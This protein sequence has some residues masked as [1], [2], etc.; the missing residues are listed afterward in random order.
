[1]VVS[2]SVQGSPAPRRGIVTTLV[3]IASVFAFLGIFASWVDQQVFDTDE[4]TDTSTELLE[5]EEVRRAVSTYLV[6][7]L[8]KN[9]DVADEL[10][11]VLP[12]ETQALA[13]PVAGALRELAPRAANRALESP[14]VQDVWAAANRRAHERFLD[15]IEDRGDAVSTAGGDVT[16]D[17]RLLVENLS[18][19]T[20]FGQKLAAK[21]PADAGQLEIMKSDELGFAQDVA[22]VI[23]GFAVV[24]PFVWLGICGLAIYLSPG[25]RHETVRAA[26]WGLVL[27]GVV[28]LISR[29]FSGDA[30]VGALAETASVEPAV[31]D[32][33]SIST[34]LLTE[35]A[36][37]VITVGVLILIGVWLA[38]RTR[39]A[40]ALRRAAAPYIR[41]RP[42]LAYGLVVAVYLLL[43]I[44][45][46]ARA[47]T[48][49]VPLFIIA[50]LMLIGTEALRRQTRR[51]FPNAAMP[52]GGIREAIG[53]LRSRPKR[54][55]H[56]EPRQP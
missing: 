34:S 13:G 46:P 49:A 25:R 43:V 27:A 7:E 22:K 2:A 21:V 31:H 33:W 37:S 11:R 51:E 40:V 16:L 4:W 55:G 24:I 3:V 8:Y 45:A 12:P 30:V 19:R 9:V 39:F 17:L 1:V 23:N 56:D 48:R 53:G 15:V 20:G 44:W 29:D 5:D 28:V 18:N 54:A 6:D 10:Q 14:P 32:V 52:E 26:A 38:G 50:A 47:F 41:E 42:G 35:I 36:Q